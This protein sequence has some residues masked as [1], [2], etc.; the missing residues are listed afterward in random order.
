MDIKEETQKVKNGSMRYAV[1][2]VGLIV[3]LFS[4]SIMTWKQ[5]AARDAA[6]TVKALQFEITEL[7]REIEEVENSGEK[8]EIREEIKIIEEEDLV[9]ARIELESERVDADNNI[10]ITSMLHFGGLALSSL[11]LVV[12]AALGGSHEKIGALVALGFVITQ[13]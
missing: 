3:L 5:S 9:D 8:K 6:G 2:F 10:W 7:K 4:Q 13:L 12:I 1:L 11:G